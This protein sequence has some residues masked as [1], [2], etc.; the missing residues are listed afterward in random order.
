TFEL[1]ITVSK[2]INVQ[3]TNNDIANTNAMQADGYQSPSRIEAKR[4][5][6]STT[7]KNSCSIT[8]EALV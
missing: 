3:I 5:S 6:E 8:V 7:G 2:F 4:F 1:P